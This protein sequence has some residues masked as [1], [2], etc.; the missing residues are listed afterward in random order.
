MNDKVS[1]LTIVPGASVNSD[2]FLQDVRAFLDE[3]L[4]I[5]EIDEDFVALEQ[6]K[7]DE[8]RIGRLNAEEKQMFILASLLGVTIED[9]LIELG[10]GTAEKIAAF[11]RQ[12]RMDVNQATQVYI[13][14]QSAEDPSL[15]EFL[16]KLIASHTMLRTLYEWKVRRRLNIWNG[17]MIVRHEFVVHTFART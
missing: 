16:M 10:A 4:D 14:Q 3:F 12:N 7:S 13:A 15:Q 6:A 8:L 2:A 5:G 9:E 1:T 11:A 17:D